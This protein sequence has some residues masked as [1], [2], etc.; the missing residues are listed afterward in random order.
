MGPNPPTQQEMLTRWSSLSRGLSA[1]LPAAPARPQIHHLVVLLNDRCQMPR[2]R[3]VRPVVQ[4]ASF[5]STWTQWW[6]SDSKTSTIFTRIRRKSPA[7]DLLALSLQ[8]R[9]DKLH[10]RS[11]LFVRAKQNGGSRFGYLR[12]FP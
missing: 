1:F 7:G 12:L 3:P 9:L 4:S 2:A 10:L 5:G 11:R 6:A 8:S